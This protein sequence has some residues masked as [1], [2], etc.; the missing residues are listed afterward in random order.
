MSDLFQSS[1]EPQ[2]QYDL[3][4]LKADID[5]IN[6]ELVDIYDKD[7]G[8]RCSI[9]NT[10]TG[11]PVISLAHIVPK[12]MVDKL[13]HKFQKK[14]NGDS[15]A[16]YPLVAI[17]ID[18]TKIERYV[19]FIVDFQELAKQEPD[20]TLSINIPQADNK[21]YRMCIL[22]AAN[23]LLPEDQQIGELDIT[24]QDNLNKFHAVRRALAGYIFVHRFGYPVPFELSLAEFYLYDTVE[25][26]DTNEGIE[27]YIEIDSYFTG[28]EITHS[29]QK[30]KQ[31]I[32]ER[33]GQREERTGVEAPKFT[34]NDKGQWI[35]NSQKDNNIA[36]N[37]SIDGTDE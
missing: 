3:L 33:F 24:N 10:T 37:R 16:P 7:Q 17:P 4:D 5:Y 12:D 32:R 25:G 8:R 21:V 23:I 31:K 13:E 19:D 26:V 20:D 34:I 14:Y 28:T 27:F 11:L 1:P 18:P 6:N 15:R 9:G 30:L 2:E 35:V 22:T 36:T 29:V